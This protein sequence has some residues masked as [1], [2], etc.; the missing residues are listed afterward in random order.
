MEFSEM[1]RIWDSQNQEPLYA[2]NEAALHSIVQRKNEEW[3]R[4]Q[5]RCF[6]LEIGVGL[7]CTGL[8]LVYATVLAFGDPRWLIK[9]WKTG[10]VPT[11][12]HYLGLFVAGGLWLYYA[13]YMYLARKRQLRRIDR[14]DSSL[15]GDLDRALSQTEFEMAMIRDNAWLGLAPVWVASTIWMVVLFHLKG[16]SFWTYVLLIA[17][18]IALLVIVLARKQRLIRDRYLP[19]RRELESLRAKLADTAQ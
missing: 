2:M 10:V 15:R 7:F 16:A 8:I 19:R 14:F 6:A 18:A 3:N 9:P 11:S 4:C 1:K 17:V 5:A 13:V 12:W